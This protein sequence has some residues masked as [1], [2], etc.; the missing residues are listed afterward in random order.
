[1]EAGSAEIAPTTTEL[2]ESAVAESQPDVLRARP[3]TQVV[4][5]LQEGVGHVVES[6][7]A[8]KTR[9]TAEVVGD[10]RPTGVQ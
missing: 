10:V 3:R 2:V 9:T 4:Q 8:T 7:L 6:E 5:Q 1:M